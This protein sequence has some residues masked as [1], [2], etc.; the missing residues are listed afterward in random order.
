MAEGIGWRPASLVI[1]AVALAVIP[2]AAWVGL[3]PRTVASCPTVR[4]P[5]LTSLPD[6][7]V[8]EP[9]AEAVE[10][11]VFA[12]K[13]PAFWALAIAFAVCEGDDQRPDRHP[14]HPVRP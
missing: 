12:S 1:G 14:L 13:H 7:L 6:R 9:S 4:T 11:L 8:A 10:G 3:I 2:L 5:P